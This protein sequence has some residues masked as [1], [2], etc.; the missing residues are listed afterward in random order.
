MSTASHS[1]SNSY[2]YFLVSLCFCNLLHAPAIRSIDLPNDRAHGY[3]HHICRRVVNWTCVPY[4]STPTFNSLLALRMLVSVLGICT[5]LIAI[6]AYTPY[7]LGPRSQQPLDQAWNP[8]PICGAAKPLSCGHLSDPMFPT[9]LYCPNIFT[10]STNSKMLPK[11]N[12]VN[13]SQV[14]WAFCFFF[15]FICQTKLCDF[16]LVNYCSTFSETWKHFTYPLANCFLCSRTPIS[17]CI[18][19]L[20][21][22]SFLTRSELHRI[23]YFLNCTLLPLLLWLSLLLKFFLY[24][25]WLL[26]KS[27]VTTWNPTKNVALLVFPL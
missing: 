22:R 9:L 14:N 20:L 12:L 24:L 15:V 16:P 17:L 26:P 27:N 2:H 23:I 3:L 18:V 8:P 1:I 21:N 4:F 19:I 10:H 6:I 5:T 25:Q 11:N 7:N 13:I